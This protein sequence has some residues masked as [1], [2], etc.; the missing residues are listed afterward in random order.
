MFIT[1][2]SGVTEEQDIQITRSCKAI[3]IKSETNP[4]LDAVKATYK[5]ISANGNKNIADDYSILELS[6]MYTQ[7]D[8]LF[9][10]NSTGLT[11]SFNNAVSICF[12]PVASG[13]AYALKN[14]EYISLDLEGLTAATTYKVYALE[15]ADLDGVLYDIDKAAVNAPRIEQRFES[16]VETLVLPEQSLDRI[17]LF[18]PDGVDVNYSVD[19][20]IAESIV[21]ND[22][23]SVTTRTLV[24]TPDVDV[25]DP[26]YGYSKLFIL[27]LGD[28]IAYQ[29][30][31]T[32]SS[33]YPFST[34]K[35]S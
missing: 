13:G 29:I 3:L 7:D 1:T 35:F 2:I 27:D 21:A 20:L 31:C 12:L 16:D 11:Q 15:S 17:Q 10:A 24:T 33:G 28:A 9:I 18:F 4:V 26:Q 22:L 23:I 25:A 8:G 32:G 30:H 6:E 5:V 19:E 14:G 34:I